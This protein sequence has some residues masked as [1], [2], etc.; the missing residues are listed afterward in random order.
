MKI[1]AYSQN[2]QQLLRTSLSGSNSAT[3]VDSYQPSREPLG[4]MATPL[5]T[6]MLTGTALAPPLL[7]AA[8]D[9]ALGTPMLAA[10][11]GVGVA[12]L[13]LAP[14]ASTLLAV[15]NC[16]TQQQGHKGLFFRPYYHP[17]ET[18]VKLW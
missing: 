14:V 8:L 5:G 7:G 1:S 4:Q 11:V 17:S 2:P 13:A 9:V 18:V 3:P 12:G 16:R 10:L 15:D 6:A